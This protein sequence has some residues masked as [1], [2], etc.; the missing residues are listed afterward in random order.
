MTLTTEK[1]LLLLNN[2][3]SD[4]DINRM[5]KHFLY[6]RCLNPSHNDQVISNA[7]IDIYTGVWHCKACGHSEHIIKTAMDY[8]GST[9]NEILQSIGVTQNY[10]TSELFFNKHPNLYKKE[11]NRHSKKEKQNL[12]FKE[13]YFNPKN[14]DYTKIRGYTKN[15]CSEIGITKITNGFYSN[16]YK[17]PIRFDANDTSLEFRKLERAESL[18]KLFPNSNENN[19]EQTLIDHINKYNITYKK[20][21]IL[22]NNSPLNPFIL[23]YIMKPKVLYSKDSNIKNKLYNFYNLDFNKDLILFEGTGT[24]PKVYQYYSKNCTAVFGTNISNNQLDLLSNF[25]KRI[26]IISDNDEASYN[27]IDKLNS[28]LN[29]IYVF[30]CATD[31]TYTSFIEDI[32]SAPVLSAFNFIK[33]R[34]FD[35]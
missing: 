28:E 31:D 24:H 4:Y 35:F 34:V 14:Y 21:K 11:N 6:I 33:K 17:I 27:M 25:K 29:N 2:L 5:S 8:H 20:G 22:S 12:Y 1:I 23:N 26:I 13:T 10:S 7:F 3:P 19:I 16:Y 30:D 32:E 15:Y 9:Y 18:Q